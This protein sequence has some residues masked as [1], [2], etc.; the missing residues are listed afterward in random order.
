M[1]A[2]AVVHIHSDWSYDG[3]WDLS[4]IVGFFGKIGYD[5][6]LTA[7]HDRTFDSDRWA[8]YKNACSEASTKR[9]LIVPGIEYSDPDNAIHI[10]VWGVSEFMGKDHIIGRLLHT[11]HGKNGI[12][13]L[14][15]PRRRNV[16]QQIEP[17][18][19]PLLSG[20]ELWNRKS[21]GIAPS[22]HAIDLLRAN[23]TI[24]PYAALD[25]HQPKQIFPLSM[26]IEIT[27]ERTVEQVFQALRYSQCRSKA[28]GISTIHFTGGLLL[29]MSRTADKIR[30]ALS[31]MIKY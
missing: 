6:V 22:Q 10:L 2:K 8:A 9:T 24:T 16:W 27:G 29:A 30:R 26:Q 31:K 25:F 7:E 18:W 20:I 3:N 21:D 23:K 4:R 11:A 5:L 1:I 17:S 15:H 28:F 12:C 13:V 14:A 19:L